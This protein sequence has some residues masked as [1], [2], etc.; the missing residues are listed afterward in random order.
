MPVYKRG[1][2]FLLSVGS[3]KDRIRK[4]FKTRAEAELAEKRLALVKEGVLEPSEVPSLPLLKAGKGVAPANTLGAAYEL[5]VKDVWSQNKGDNSIRVAKRVLRSVG[6]D[7]LVADVTTSLIRELVEEWED[8]GNTGGTVNAK[9]S[10]I[11]MMLKTACD[12]GWLEAMPRIKRRSPG[13][14][15]IRWMDYDE[16]MQA[17]NLCDKL[18]LLALKD[19]I[20]FAIDTGF[21]KME[22]LEFKGKE[23]RGNML[24]LHPDE[25]KTSKARAIPPTSRVL[26]ILQKRKN[27]TRV[28]D[29]LTP[30]KLRDHWAVLREAMGKLDDPQFVVHMLRHTCASRLAM[31]DKTAQFIQYWMGHSSP[32]TTARYMHLA[33]AKMLEGATALDQYRQAHQ[34][35][36]KVV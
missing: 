11:S 33:P 28:F 6:E 3:G 13:T 30:C 21:R 27:N 19:Y 23:Y 15:R 36:L 7:T 9:L 32:L 29:D 10:A 16:E 31:Q 8:A 20:M 18:G 12:E 4:A 5:T 2:T 35:M 25:T 14:H 22:Q 26:E 34:P 24:H 1:N 17:L